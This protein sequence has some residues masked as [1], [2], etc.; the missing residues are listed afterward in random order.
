MHSA[1]QEPRELGFWTCTAL[2]IGNTIGIGIFVLP[3]SLAPQGLNALWAWLVT[4]VGC[5]FLAVVF[6]G[7]ARSFPQDD[8]PYAYTHRAFGP[9]AA[10]AVLWCYWISCWLTNAFL[11]IGAVGYLMP[12]VP[13]LATVPWLPSVTALSLVWF[14]VL[15]NLFGVRA[16]GGI[17]LVM[18]ALKLV[19]QAAVIWFGVWLLYKRPAA[20]VA[21][22]PPNPFSVHDLLLA[23][24]TALY[25]MLGIECA[26]IP[27]AR[28][29]DPGRTIPRSTLAGTLITAFI[30]LCISAIPILLVPQAELATSS[31][32][33]ADLI[34]HYVGPQYG[35]LLAVCVVISALGALNGWTLL[36]GELTQ[37]FSRHGTLPALL[38]A[39]NSHAAPTYAFLLTGVLASVMLL[40]NYTQSTAGIYT[41]FSQMVTAANLPLY[42]ACSLAVL[43][44]WKRGER[45]RPGA[46]ELVWLG[47]AALA[48]LYCL[49]VVIGTDTASLRWAVG[50]GASGVLVYGGAFW[51]RRRR[52]P[53]SEIS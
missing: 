7:L 5:C 42:V 35:R 17:Q 6:S 53:L 45:A 43:V 25:A 37:T 21:H 10:F 14:F 15:I 39:E 31:A 19:P 50:L 4:T 11:A 29:R 23:S 22:V 44:L 38:G 20:Y 40:A 36:T 13:A 52:R 32:P 12:L 3:A 24:T 2:V 26:T 34:A 46:R 18:T 33:F 16:A 47:G 48:T 51:V 8:G 30:Y 41:F 9:A 28:V 1:T 27:A 49:W